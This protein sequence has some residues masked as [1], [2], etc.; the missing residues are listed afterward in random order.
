M[1]DSID[2]LALEKLDFLKRV[3]VG[4][5][6]FSILEPS[7]TFDPIPKNYDVLLYDDTEEAYDNFINDLKK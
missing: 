3:P 7:E 6:K 4:I 5:Y 1:N 2:T